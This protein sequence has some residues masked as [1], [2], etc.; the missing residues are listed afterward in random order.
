MTV[1]VTLTCACL[2]CFQD[3]AAD[4]AAPVGGAG[5][6]R[7]QWVVDDVPLPHQQLQQQQAVGGRCADKADDALSAQQR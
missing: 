5:K 1:S 4:A 7:R 6:V 2:M 3:Q